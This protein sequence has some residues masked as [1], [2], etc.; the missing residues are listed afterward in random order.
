MA[1][2]MQSAL[3]ELRYEPS[4]KWV[5]V[6]LGGAL[7]AD[8][9]SPVLVWE[10]RR[11]VP[12]YAIPL[13]D[14]VISPRD[15]DP[16]ASTTAR[17]VPIDDLGTELLDPSTGFG[18]HTCP[19]TPGRVTISPLWGATFQPD[20]LDGL[21]VLD[22]EDF[23]WFE[24]AERIFGHPRDPFSRIDLRR[25]AR[26][27]RVESDGRVLAES[28]RPLAL[29]ETHLPVRYYLPR[30]DVQIPLVASTTMTTC[31]YKGHATHWSNP[32]LGDDLAWSYENPPPEMAQITSLVSFYQEKLD[33]S[34]DGV[35]LARPGTPWNK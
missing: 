15:A 35:R 18:H 28:S 20:D 25:S 31:A 7:V 26:E 14:F 24:E 34:V 32:K 1:A 9:H 4:R 8:T 10:P 23:E 12:S 11:V 33:F 13:E 19:G 5:R 6:R 30:E 27:V 3:N 17:P 16:D 22:F 29:F 2:Y 21:V